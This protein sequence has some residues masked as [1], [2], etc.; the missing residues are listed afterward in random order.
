M[1]PVLSPSRTLAQAMALLLI[2]A[3]GLASPAHAQGPTPAADASPLIH[4]AQNTA[5]SKTA[6]GKKDGAS[7]TTDAKKTNEAG[8]ADANAEG[9]K[10]E[11]NYGPI[12]SVFKFLGDR[13]F[14][15]LFLALAIGYP[16]GALKFKGVGLGS[17]A[18][19]L[20][21]GI[22]ISLTAFVAYEIRYS[23]PGLVSDI[24]LLM[25]MYAIGLKVGPQFFSGL[26][27]GGLHFIIIGLIVVTTNWLIAF[28][29]ATLVG[30][31][32]G[33]AAGIISGSYTV[34]AVIGVA[35]SAVSSGA[36]QPPSGITADQVTANIAAGYAVS[37][38]L[39]TVGIIL[40]IKYLP[41]MFG[42]DPVAEAK[43]GEAEFAGGQEDVSPGSDESFAMG[44]P[45]FDIRAYKVEHQEIAGKTIEQLFKEHPKAPVLRVL[46]D[47]TVIE[48]SENPT[49]QLGDIIAVAAQATMLIEGGT[50]AIGPEV[51]EPQARN[52]EVEV[53]ELVI[54]KSEL[55]GKTLKE[56]ATQVGFG[57]HL[58][59][60]FRQG[61]ELPRLPDTVIE[62]GDV[63]RIAGPDWSVQKAA[64][65]FGS[66]PILFTLVTETMFL[67]LALVVGY[68]VGVV[69][70]TLKG[71]PFA[72][73]T[74]AGCMLTG[75]MVSYM[76]TR[77][78]N[79]GGPV[80]EGARSF[81]QDIGLSL[82]I[83]VLAAN[84]GPKVLNSFQGT[85]VIWIALIGTLAAL[86]PPFLAW[87]FG[88]WVLKMNPVLLAGCCAGGRN[89]TPAMSAVSAEARSSLPAVG[90][91]VP[92]ALTSVLVLIG[93]YVAMVLS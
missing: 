7:A 51:D 46:R 75:I 65:A 80:S 69:S 3:C 21:V 32:P 2:A 90:Y 27:R 13:P 44:H 59:A 60:L 16:L 63:V 85:A 49:V 86:V 62:V 68:L 30:L 78:P 70:M 23:V 26:A 47:G 40:L 48:A 6:D 14:V 76:R 8:K 55:A 56:L 9:K 82:F 91:P 4:M 92:Y 52:V 61:H 66:K 79:F 73:G 35:S 38:V 19:T 39:S 54:G 22:A 84:V 36:W 71:I 33:Y 37:Y 12:G 45:P 81:L 64:K 18:G 77:N 50:K 53:A 42:Y 31:A 17:T 28:G 58:K 67:S 24:F 89:S 72:L 25:F 1:N 93:G 41:A 11:K 29:G 15:F 10:P 74:S 57:L 5:D 88:L 20:V 34:T 87:L 83:A 43:K